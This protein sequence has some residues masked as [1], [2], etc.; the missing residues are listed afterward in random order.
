MEKKGGKHTD[1]ADLEVV[2]RPTQENFLFRDV[3][4]RRHPLFDFASR[5]R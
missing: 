2:T 3:F 1:Y 5:E 4:F